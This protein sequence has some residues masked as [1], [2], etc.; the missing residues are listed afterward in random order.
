MKRREFIAALAGATAWPLAARAQQPERVRL[1]GLLMGFSESDPAAQA[2]VT[3]FRTALAKLGWIEGGNL[4][5][6]IR[7]GNGNAARIATFAK[8]LIGLR[9]DAI[10][11]QTTSST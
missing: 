11:G 10:L 1:I 9:P 2:L 6:E 3:A 8:E 7:W 4:R 5:I